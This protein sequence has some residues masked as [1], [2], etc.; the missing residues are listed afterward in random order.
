MT[1]PP[2]LNSCALN[3]HET[4]AAQRG[5]LELDLVTFIWSM[6]ATGHDWTTENNTVIAIEQEMEWVYMSFYL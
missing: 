3:Q 1:L 2:R 6:K 4:V 5:S